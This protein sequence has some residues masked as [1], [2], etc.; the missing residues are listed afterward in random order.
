M[1]ELKVAWGFTNAGN[2]Q[3]DDPNA[4]LELIQFYGDP[5]YKS[6]FF[7]TQAEVEAFKLAVKEMDCY[8]TGYIVQK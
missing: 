5:M 3:G 4:E 1:I 6:Y 2:A 7:E 8:L